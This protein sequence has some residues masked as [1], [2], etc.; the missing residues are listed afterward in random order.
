MAM[1]T[2]LGCDGSTE[3]SGDWLIAVVPGDLLEAEGTLDYQGTAS[4]NHGVF[5]GPIFSGEKEWFSIASINA[6]RDTAHESFVVYRLGG[7][8]PA[9][10]EYDLAPL[11][12]RDPSAE[13]FTLIYSWVQED[14]AEAAVTR[15]VLASAV[16]GR[17]RITASSSAAVEGTFEAT[18]AE[19]CRTGTAWSSESIRCIE[20]WK[21]N[22]EGAHLS[23][24]GEFRAVYDDEPMIPLK[25]PLVQ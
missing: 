7:Q 19:Y 14:P 11:N 6:Q 17:L 13:G 24:T 5:H 15:T 3:P 9:I 22:T 16:S 1:A 18:V 25:G 4:Y 12:Q 23:V 20:P 8:R 10:G 21:V 2:I